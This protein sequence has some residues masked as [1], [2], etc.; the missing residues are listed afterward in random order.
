MESHKEKSIPTVFHDVIESDLP[1]REKTLDRLYQEGQTFVAAGTETTAWCLTV[2]TFYLIENPS[3]M[4]KLRAELR[5]ANAS[6]GTQLEKL[7]YL[8]AI[9]QEG[10][11]LSFGV[12]TR[13]ARIAPLDTLVLR[14]GQKTWEIPPNVRLSSIPLPTITI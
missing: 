5:N 2:I 8:S 13:L 3:I 9:I 6:T 7:P 10:L 1:A 4:E 12:C 14:D 11:R